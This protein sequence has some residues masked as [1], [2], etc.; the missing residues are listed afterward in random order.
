MKVAI[1]MFQRFELIEARRSKFGHIFSNKVYQNSQLPKYV[2]NKSCSPIYI[3]FNEKK[4][5]KIRMIFE[6]E[7]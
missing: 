2:N 4:F 7:K 5:R 1:K 3:F 6:I